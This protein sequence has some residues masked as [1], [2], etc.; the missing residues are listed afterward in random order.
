ML[1]FSDFIL[2]YYEKNSQ[3]TTDEEKR[4]SSKSIS[5]KAKKNYSNHNK[6][7][8]SFDNFSYN[9]EKQK[10]DSPSKHHVSNHISLSLKANGPF[11]KNKQQL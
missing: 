8:K 5:K 7:N 10:S 11:K 3:S 9:E 6:P 4:S 1:S 2:F